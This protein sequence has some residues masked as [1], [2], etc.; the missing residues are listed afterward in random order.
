VSVIRE[1]W[2]FAEVQGDPLP[3]RTDQMGV[4]S[5]REKSVR[6]FSL[7][8]VS[9]VLDQKQPWKGGENKEETD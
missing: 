2:I 1:K 7:G 9:G 3:T 4:A 6:G 5:L 8:M